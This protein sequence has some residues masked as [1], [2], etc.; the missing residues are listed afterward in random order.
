MVMHMTRGRRALDAY[1]LVVFLLGTSAAAWAQLT[2]A[3]IAALRERGEREGWTFTVG[4][5]EATQRPIEQLCGTLPS[6]DG[7]RGARF[8]PCLPERALPSTWDWRTALSLPAVRNQGNCGS[9]WAFG[10]I[11]AMECALVREA[12]IS[13][14][15]SEQWL[16]SCTSAG[17]C[18]GGWTESALEYLTCGGGQ[19]PCG[20]NG[21][22][23]ESSFPYVAWDAPCGCPYEH[24]YCLDSW[25]LVGSQWSDPS[26]EQIKQAIY[27]HGPVVVGVRAGTWAFAAYSGGIFNACESGMTDHAVLLVGWDDNQAG[28]IWFL[29]NSWGPGW[30]EGGYM[31][32]KYGCNRVGRLAAYVNYLPPDCNQNGI[33]DRQDI[34]D[35]TSVDCNGNTVPD[36]CEPNGTTDCNTNGVSDLCDL[37]TGTSADCNANKRP[38]ECD[39]ADGTSVDCNANGIPDECELAM[40][41]RKDDGTWD[42]YLWGAYSD[43]YIWLNQ[44]KVAPGGETINAVEIAWGWVPSG[45]PATI[46]VWRDPNG[47][48]DPHDAILLWTSAPVGVVGPLTETFQR[49]EVPDV[50]V[51]AAGDTFFVGAYM[52][53]TDDWERWPGL[54]DG[55]VAV[56]GSWEAEGDNLDDLSA[57]SALACLDDSLGGVFMIRARC[58]P[59]DCNANGVLD[60]CDIEDG[61]SNDINANRVPDECEPDCNA[62]GAPDDFDIAQGLSEDCNT[63]GVPDECETNLGVS[64][65]AHPTA[66]TA[67]E[68]DPV[69]FTV[70]ASGAGTLKYQWRRYFVPVPGATGSTFTIPAASLADAGVY[71]VEVSS[72]CTSAL[73]PARKSVPVNLSVERVAIVDQPADQT[74]LVGETATFSVSASALR[75]LTFQWHKDGQPIAGA[76]LPSF[77]VAPA[78]VEDAGVYTVAVAGC[79]AALSDGAGLTVLLARPDLPSPANGAAD[80]SPDVVLGWSVVPGADEYDVFLGVDTPLA[81]AGTTPAAKFTPGT[82][83]YGT[84]YFWTVVARRGDLTTEGVTW[85]FV[86]EPAPVP[87]PGQP[88]EP[89]PAD[90]AANV[91]R[92]VD[93]TWAQAE[94]ATLYKV[95]V[96]EDAALTDGRL[97]ASSGLCKCP[98]TKLKSK[99][100][101]YWQVIAKNDGGHVAGTIWSFTTE[102]PAAPADSNGA[103]G[104]VSPAEPDTSGDGT[105]PDGDSPSDSGLDSPTG[106]SALCPAMSSALL[107][108]TC[109]GLRGLRGH[110]G[111]ARRRRRC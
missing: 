45:H 77:T 107:L 83:A 76:V 109:L 104:A 103:N 110:G 88:S 11:G 67:C 47:D 108:A 25:L 85:W 78:T 64:I 1:V 68:G 57:N 58:A 31:R 106:G 35:G 87:L 42:G 20:G 69:T 52:R 80:V 61:T 90:G 60:E 4:H 24:P 17:S 53:L 37:F 63:N 12:S 28:G 39:I 9:C 89:Y 14:N 105:P 5:N 72:S 27:D 62:N 48:G 40:S 96:G 26:V 102:A 86:T 98:L 65:T 71:D 50:R 94:G 49:V 55:S 41:Y 51:G 15:L 92:E 56:G 97:Q 75:Q 29:R 30:G 73:Y 100:T 82:L 36:E 81:L 18:D 6:P 2:D 33:P 95:L 19:D 7:Q 59:P 44:F 3:D 74:V 10:A 43:H 46:A 91:P 21:A 23:L 93:L 8:D 13:V 22:V 66:V 38:D 70:G 16:V 111:G 32:I 101:Y 34:A 99:T 54:W 84:K 79:G